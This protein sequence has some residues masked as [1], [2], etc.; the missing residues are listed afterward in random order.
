M[1]IY[2]SYSAGAS[3]EFCFWKYF[4]Q[5]CGIWITPKI[6][7]KNWHLDEIQTPHLIILDSSDED[8]I[9]S[10]MYDNVVYCVR[11]SSKAGQR[12]KDVIKVVWW[13]QFYHDVLNH[14]FKNNRNLKEWHILLNI[15][16]GNE[17]K[18]SNEV[19]QEGLWGANWLFHEMGTSAETWD[20]EIKSTVIK[21]VRMLQCYKGTMGNFWNYQYMLLYCDYLLCGVN[22][23]QISQIYTCKELLERCEEFA[24]EKGWFPILHVLAAKIAVLVPTENKYAVS[25]L[26]NAVEYE[27]QAD[28][29]YEIGHVYEK[30]YGDR[31][32]AMQ[33]YLEAN[34]CDLDYYRAVY[35]LAI[36]FENNNRWIMAMEKYKEIQE[37]IYNMRV[38]NSIS[39]RELEYEYKTCRRIV[40]ICKKKLEASEMEENYQ[41]RINELIQNPY[42]SV[43]FHKLIRVMLQRR[44]DM[45]CCNS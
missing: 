13:N 40:Q 18:V 1:R 27:E 9:N 30:A 10:Q 17:N 36:E 42:K 5:T 33:Y 24:Q 11:K 45:L 12:R 23:S 3:V 14:L 28:L 44:L 25:Y 41:Q 37:I 22:R 38:G 15:Y 43:N 35:K 16:N 32:K 31:A 19:Q 6:I 26:K 21:T 2:I 29:L 7:K 39:V 20:N 8:K 4:F 34:M